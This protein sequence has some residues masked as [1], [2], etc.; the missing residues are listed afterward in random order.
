[1]A[2]ATLVH[3]THLEAVKHQRRHTTAP[4]HQQQLEL[5]SLEV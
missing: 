1:M 4:C 2:L 5:K 3:I